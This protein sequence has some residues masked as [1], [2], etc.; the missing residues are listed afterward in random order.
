MSVAVGR[1]VRVCDS[2]ARLAFI[3]AIRLERGGQRSFMLY[4]TEGGSQHNRP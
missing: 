3:S 4:L 2:P 1:A